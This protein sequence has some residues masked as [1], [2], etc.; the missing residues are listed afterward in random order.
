MHYLQGKQALVSSLQAA[1]YSQQSRPLPMPSNHC[2]TP[3]SNAIAAG[4]STHFPQAVMSRG[5]QEGSLADQFSVTHAQP[6]PLSMLSFSEA[7]NTAPCGVLNGPTRSPCAEV[8]TSHM[9]GGLDGRSAG[10]SGDISLAISA[11]ISDEAASSAGSNPRDSPVAIRL[12]VNHLPMPV[13]DASETPQ[14]LQADKPVPSLSAHADTSVCKISN[15]AELQSPSSQSLQTWSAAEASVA[16]LPSAEQSV[17]EL[18]EAMLPVMVLPAAV[19]RLTE[20]SPAEACAADLLPLSAE[21]TAAGRLMQRPCSPAT[22]QG[23]CSLASM[24]VPCS[25][26]SMQGPCSPANMQGPCF[27]ASMQDLEALSS[28]PSSIFGSPAASLSKP[29]DDMGDREVS[30]SVASPSE[31][32]QSRSCPSSPQ[33]Q[34]MGP[35]PSTACK[36]AGMHPAALPEHSSQ[37]IFEANSTSQHAVDGNTCSHDTAEVDAYSQ[38]TAETNLAHHATAQVTSLTRVCI[39]SLADASRAAAQGP[40]ILRR[41]AASV[42]SCALTD[43]KCIDPSAAV[44][45]LDASDVVRALGEQDDLGSMGHLSV[46]TSVSHCKESSSGRLART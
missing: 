38:H 6:A 20:P 2:D 4:T 1:L 35:S 30:A 44:T 13:A 18:P 27:T 5:S 39:D 24:Q 41:A 14:A 42:V 8:D 22:M 10:S 33:Q 29:H 31:S 17:A 36:A 15:S 37:T 11:K 3:S 34:S 28:Q 19:N 45:Q 9:L 46:D 12:A 16:P 43:E 26:A 23:P 32:A 25:P 7:S 21:A 40:S